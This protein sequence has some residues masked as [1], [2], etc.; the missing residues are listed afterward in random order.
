M[1]GRFFFFL[2]QC[3]F[4]FFFLFSS[5]KSVQTAC[6]LFI[7]LPSCQIWMVVGRSS[8]KQI[9]SLAD[10][11][12]V[13]S[14]VSPHSYTSAAC[15]HTYI[16]RRACARVSVIFSVCWRR[17]IALYKS[18]VLNAAHIVIY[19]YYTRV[20]CAY[21]ILFRLYW[22]SRQRG[23]QDRGRILFPKKRK[24]KQKRCRGLWLT[25]HVCQWIRFSQGALRKIRH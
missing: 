12:K 13:R 24:K 22:I 15:I 25:S 2:Q 5:S 17:L 23:V 10:I 16:H 20:I 3:F 14:P 19:T 9:R 8:F 7:C 1:K 6:C 18:N 21:K 4:F 11:C